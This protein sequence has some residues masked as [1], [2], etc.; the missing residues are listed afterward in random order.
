[1]IDLKSITISRLK[2]KH[3]PTHLNIYDRIRSWKILRQPK[4]HHG[5]NI[6]FKENVEVSICETGHLSIGDHSFFHANVYLLL[7]MPRPKVSIG[8]WVFVGRNTI[9]AAKNRIRIGDYTIFAP[10][11]YVIDHEHG[12]SADDVILN[13]QSELKEVSIGRDCYFGTGSVVLG[14]VEIGDGAIVG[15]GSVITRNIP[16]YQ[17]W[18]GNPAKYIKDRK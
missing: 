17:I 7:T 8:Q 15:A 1:M 13:Q 10:N 2:D 5:R 11:C 16:P 3:S 14:G 9:I 18:A 6:T 12:F 4:I